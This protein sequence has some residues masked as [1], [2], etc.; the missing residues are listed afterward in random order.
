MI[1]HLKEN[2]LTLNSLSTKFL[3]TTSATVNSDIQQG[4]QSLN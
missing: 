1:L 3:L 2:L 4:F